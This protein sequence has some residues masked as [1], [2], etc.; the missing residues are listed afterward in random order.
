MLSNSPLH[1]IWLFV[2]VSSLPH[3]AA[4]SEHSPFP[5]I[6][7]KAFSGFIATNFSSKI[8]LATV[9]LLLFTMTENPELLSLHARQQNREFK[10]EKSTTLSAW[11]KSL[12]RSLVDHRHYSNQ[13]RS[14]TVM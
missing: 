2:A 9:L 6:T 10:G 12:S 7:F 13:G 1:F 5:D 14:A 3:A 8:S 4:M 11:I